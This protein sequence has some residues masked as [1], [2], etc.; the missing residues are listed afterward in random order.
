MYIETVPN[1]NSP[2]AVLLRESWWDKDAKRS[3]KR[4]L[5]NLSKLSPS[6]IA[7]LK[8][9]LQGASIQTLP[10]AMTIPASWPHGHVAAALGM[11][12]QLGLETLIAARRSRQRDRVTARIVARILDPQAK[13]ATAPGLSPDSHTSSLGPMLDLG[14]TEADELYAA[15]DWLGAR[16]E[17]IETRLAQRHLADGALVL[18][19]RTSVWMEGRR[20]DLAA[21]GY[22]RDG[23]KGKTQIE[24]GL[25]CDR[26][27]RPVAVEVFDGHTSDPASVSTAVR[28]VRDRFGLTRVVIVGDRG[29]LTEARIRDDI[30]PAGLDWIGALRAPA[31]RKLVANDTLQ[32]SLLDERDLAEITCEELFPGERLIVCRN[33][34]LA[35][36]RRRKRPA[37]LDATEEAIRRVEAATQRPNRRLQGIAAITR[38]LEPIRIRHK[39]RKHFTFTIQDDGFTGHRKAESIAE[40]E[41]LDG[42]YVVRTSLPETVMDASETVRSY[43]RL[44]SV[45]R[46]FRSL[47]TVDL[48]V[49][50]VYHR[51]AHRVRAHVRLCMLAYYVEWPMRAAW[52][53]L[54][55]HDDG[56]PPRPSVVA[57]AIPSS[58]AR[59][60]ATT[61]RTPEGLPVLR[62]A[63]RLKHLATLTRIRLQPTAGSDVTVDMTT[64]PTPLQKRAFELLGVRL[65]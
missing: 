55:F 8:A 35:D 27:G 54:L 50:P 18:W 29:M 26:E 32:P 12:R 28:R 64:T 11:L 58:Q 56:T 15:M 61:R 30:E 17:R 62:F 22:S 63:D 13:L 23:K 7:N 60:K 46:A 65:P 38:R 3:R 47:K 9:C 57:P 49:R 1:R 2:P 14:P 25:L 10:E 44:A 24:F 37:L 20:C 51:R 45:E 31:I 33:P 6:V 36:E 40:E 39:M 21:Y 48:K 59:R 42:I 52:Q 19:D 53:S 5:A 43:K 16:Q 4:T 41:A 34:L